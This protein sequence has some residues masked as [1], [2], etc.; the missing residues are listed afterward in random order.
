[1]RNVQ[2]KKRRSGLAKEITPAEEGLGGGFV[3]FGDGCWG[4]TNHL[5]KKSQ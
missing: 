2:T 3:V 4:G 5:R 1:M